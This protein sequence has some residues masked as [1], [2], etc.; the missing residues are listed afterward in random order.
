MPIILENVSFSYSRKT[1]LETPALRDINLRIEKGEFVGILGE[2]GAGKS[3][4]T[5]LF[6]G[7]LKPETG[8]IR[9]DGL[10]PSSR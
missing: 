5:K 6:N 1:P 2:K 7:L 8:T 9:V 10:D 3:T 4:L